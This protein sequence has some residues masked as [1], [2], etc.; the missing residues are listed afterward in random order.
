MENLE[1]MNY[2]LPNSIEA[3]KAVLGSLML[4][5]VQV[6]TIQSIITDDDFYLEKHRKIFQAME[7]LFDQERTIDVVTLID[8]LRSVNELDNVGGEEYIIELW[9]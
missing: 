5:S 7:Q 4:D 9:E 3:E 6:G 8:L 2:Q 1:T